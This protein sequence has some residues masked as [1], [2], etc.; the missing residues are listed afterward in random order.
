MRFTHILDRPIGGAEV[1]RA[2]RWSASL[3]QLRDPPRDRLHMPLNPL[4]VRSLLWIA[5]LL[6]RY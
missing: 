5:S 3:V 2:Q 4:R 6:S 1:V